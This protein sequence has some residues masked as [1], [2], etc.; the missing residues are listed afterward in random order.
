MVAP[1]IKIKELTAGLEA[2]FDLVSKKITDNPVKLSID[3]KR[4][5]QIREEYKKP[6]AV[7][8]E[9]Q[10]ERL[11]GIVGALG[12]GE[13]NIANSKVVGAAA[14]GNITI[15]AP[16]TINEAQQKTGNSREEFANV[17]NDLLK[18]VGQVTETV[19]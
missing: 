3:E 10:L 1:D 17:F 15:N 8:D 18:K 14:G 16:T 2:Q 5:E 7:F 6:L 9:K 11:E 19:K 4:L 12:K 13:T